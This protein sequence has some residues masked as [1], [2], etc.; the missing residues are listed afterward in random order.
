MSRVRRQGEGRLLVAE[1]LGVDAV[2]AVSDL[3]GPFAVPA[4]DTPAGPDAHDV[5]LADPALDGQ[6]DL[7]PLA[8]ADGGFEKILRDVVR[9]LTALQLRRDGSGGKARRHKES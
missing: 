8:L 3:A 4:V 1:Q 9:E 7:D 2:R 5:A 6:L